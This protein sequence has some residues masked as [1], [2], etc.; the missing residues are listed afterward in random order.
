MSTS[1]APTPYQFKPSRKD[2]VDHI[3]VSLPGAQSIKVSKLSLIH[4]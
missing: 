1:K 2:T 3:K 4:I